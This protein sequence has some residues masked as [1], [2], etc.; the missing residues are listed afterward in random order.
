M[1]SGCVALQELTLFQIALQQNH[2]KSNRSHITDALTCM[3]LKIY[4]QTQV[5]DFQEELK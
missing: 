1:K 4:N 2:D 3:V 5:I